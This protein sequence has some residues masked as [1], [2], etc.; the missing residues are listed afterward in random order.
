MTQTQ[1]AFDKFSATAARIGADPALILDFI[2]DRLQDETPARQG[3]LPD[4]EARYIEQFAGLNTA[5]AI[6]PS[7]G[8]IVA[9]QA[10]IDATRFATTHEVAKILGIDESRVRH[11]RGAGDLIAHKLGRGLRYPLWQFT[12]GQPHSVPLPGLA[13][14]VAILP[15]QMHPAEIAG[16]MLTPQAELMIG[17]RPVSPREWLIAGGQMDAMQEVFDDDQPW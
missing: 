2:T 8:E 14:L 6:R 17:G 10:A 3:L 11:R 4:A 9:R 15:P 1:A 5:A 7:F 12:P 13:K 16:R